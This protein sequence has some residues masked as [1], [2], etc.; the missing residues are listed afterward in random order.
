[1]WQARLNRGLINIGARRVDGRGRV[2]PCL[3]HG[4]VIPFETVQD[5]SDRSLS[6]A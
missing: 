5:P 2:S 1:M 6:E 4:L 3:G